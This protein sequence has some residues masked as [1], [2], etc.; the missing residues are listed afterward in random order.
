[1]N[2]PFDNFPGLIPSS[3][4]GHEG[5]FIHGTCRDIPV[6]IQSGRLH[7]YEG[8]DYDTVV[9]PVDVLHEAGVRTIV[10]TNA[11]GALDLKLQP[12]NLITAT[13][14][15]TWPFVGWP[16]RPDT[17]PT[18]FT[19]SGCDHEGQYMWVHGPS[20]ETP[21][22]IE[23]LRK[24]GGTVVGMSAAP[25]VH[26]AQALGMRTAVISCVTNVCGSDEAINHE[27][28]VSV[29][30]QSSGRLRDLLERWIFTFE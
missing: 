11:A 15:G 7:F 12:G 4:D 30:E 8:L 3:V 10:F 26:R 2:L 25:E 28:V 13:S 9:R 27:D 17:I 22:E 5:T 1:M 29:A 20:Y 21:A 6:I 19:V 16:N 18:D 23:V 24:M 14:L